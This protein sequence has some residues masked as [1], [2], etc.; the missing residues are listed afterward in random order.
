M[1]NYQGFQHMIRTATGD[2]AVLPVIPPKPNG[3]D[4]ISG[5]F[6]HKGRLVAC[7]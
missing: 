2:I 6:P 5:L 4:F 1:S 7:R 3:W